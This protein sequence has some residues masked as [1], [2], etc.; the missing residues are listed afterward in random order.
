MDPSPLQASL[1]FHLNLNYSAI[2]VAERGEVVRR[3]YRPLLELCDRLPWLVLAVE[4][5]GHT[6]E[7]IE[8]L[9]PEWIARLRRRWSE[10]RV[11]FV[12]SGDCQL[13]GPLVPASVNRWNQRLGVETYERLLGRRPRSVLVNELA[14]SQGLVDVYHEA[15]YEL[16]LTEWN[17]PRRNH[18]EWDGEWRFRTARTESPSGA[19]LPLAWID[20][21]AFQKF[22]RVVMGESA[23]D[24]YVDWVLDQRGPTR[25]HL[26]LYANDAEIFDYRPGRYRGEPRLEGTGEWDRMARIL[27]ALHAR[28]V[29][30]T[31]PMDEFDRTG[32]D[33]PTV[34]LNCAADPVP[35][36]KQPKYNATRW[37]LSGWDDAGINARCFARARELEEAAVEDPEP[38]R[39]L[40]RAWGSDLRTHLTPRRWEAFQRALPSAPPK[41]AGPAADAPLARCEIREDRRRLTVETDRVRLVLLPRRGLAIESLTLNEVAEEPLLGTLP[42]GSFAEIDWSADF[43]SGHTVM[44]VPAR[45]RVTDLEAT[46]PWVERR[47]D[48]VRVRATVATELGP[49]AKQYDVFA[50][51]VELSIEL[52]G[53]GERPQ[54]S[55]RTAITTLLPGALGPGL[56]ITCANGGTAERFPLTGDCDHGASVSPIVS[57][58]ATFGATDGTLVVDDGRHGFELVWPNWSV[59]ALPLLTCKNLEGGRFVRLSFSLAELDETRRPGAPLRDFR[60]TIRPRRTAA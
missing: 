35:V 10:G 53:L 48:R 55:V 22:Q 49:L 25:R 11:E 33:A 56:A 38:W 28:G 47:P 19:A 57:A 41:G 21:I 23:V 18:P 30:F 58:G 37:A 52:S 43:Y 16:L 9:D 7:R 24:E 14:W 4:A 8:R 1:L 13:I 50:D 51:R 32:A 20:A 3:C 60:L 42:H 45:P 29:E 27:E 44:E 6:L 5:S 34:T 46:E 31:R 17:N 59:A 40:C 54:G 26:F 15:G 39:L 12:G 2:E 36:K